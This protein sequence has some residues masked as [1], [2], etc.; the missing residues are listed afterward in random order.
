MSVSAGDV[1]RCTCR[2]SFD[3][4]EDIINVLHLEV[5]TAPTP[6]DDASLLADLSE[7][8]G[9]NY[10]AI[11]AEQ[12]TSLDAV[13]ITVYNIT[14]DRPI[15]VTSWATYTG[16]TSGGEALP[17]TDALLVL[18]DTGVKRRQGRIYFG[19]FTEAQQNAG[20]WVAGVRTDAAVLAYEM[21]QPQVLGQL[22][23]YNLIV[24]S[25]TDG[26]AYPITTIRAQPIV[27]VQKR[28]KRGRGS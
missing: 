19:G 20:I 4:T 17:P 25:P 24:W 3:I 22:G 21:T 8:L 15:G 23:Q 14:D 2:C 18:L 27:A 28:R 6:N 7:L 11:Q 5:V 16:G 26:D 12:S 1:L 10:T 9:T 13:D